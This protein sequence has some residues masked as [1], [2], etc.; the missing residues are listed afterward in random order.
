MKGHIHKGRFDKGFI[1]CND[2]SFMSTCY[3]SVLRGIVGG[4][5]GSILGKV[6]M[7]TSAQI[8]LTF[9]TLLVFVFLNRTSYI[10]IKIGRRGVILCN[11]TLLFLSCVFL[12][13][14]RLFL[15]TNGIGFFMEFF[16]FFGVVGF[17]EGKPAA[18]PPTYSSFFEGV[19]EELA[20][21]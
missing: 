5:L 8:I 12:A 3:F 2:Y 16:L 11:H 19:S 20:N 7:F 21:L 4:F 15:Y 18:N 10:Y 1:M 13:I 14:L 6:L 17:Q 9:S